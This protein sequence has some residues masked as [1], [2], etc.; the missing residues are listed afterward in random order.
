MGYSI[1]TMGIKVRKKRKNRALHAK[2][3]G[4]QKYLEL[5]KKGK[6][7]FVSQSNTLY[8]HKDAL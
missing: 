6:R 3:I 1:T 2:I 8:C 4:V 7:P 5:F